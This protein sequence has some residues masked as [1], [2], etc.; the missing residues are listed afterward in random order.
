[1]A[2]AASREPEAPSKLEQSQADKQS[3]SYYHAHATPAAQDAPKLPVRTLTSYSLLDDGGCCEDVKVWIPLEGDLRGIAAS[4]VESA[5]DEFSL[6][7]SIRTESVLHQFRVD[8]L[9][10]AVDPERCKCRVKPERLVLVLRKRDK[11]FHWRRLY[12]RDGSSG[13]GLK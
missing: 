9:E 11:Y 10:A 8:R 5:F 2:T 6:T 1:M 4:A 7:V 3:L 12:G 13:L